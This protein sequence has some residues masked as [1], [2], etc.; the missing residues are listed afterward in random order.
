MKNMLIDDPSRYMLRGFRISKKANRKYDAILSDKYGTHVYIPFGDIRYEHYK[1]S[2]PDTKF[3]F[4]NNFDERRKKRY[5][6]NHAKEYNNK[7]SP[8]YFSL[9]YLWDYKHDRETLN[10][11]KLC[12]INDD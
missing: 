6:K 8:G 7:Y 1:D 4:L 11:S 12:C 3:D 9:V 5:Y 10:L 2:T